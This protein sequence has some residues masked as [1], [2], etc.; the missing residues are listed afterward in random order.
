MKQKL[1]WEH[2]FEKANFRK[3]NTFDKITNRMMI[4]KDHDKNKTKTKI[5]KDSDTSCKKNK[6]VYKIFIINY[7]LRPYYLFSKKFDISCYLSFFHQSKNNDFI[8]PMLNLLIFFK[9]YSELICL[10]SYQL[11][12]IK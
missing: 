8:F 2:F 3:R 1:I 5:I 10:I 4:D 7:F 11:I 12:G 9:K 6:Y